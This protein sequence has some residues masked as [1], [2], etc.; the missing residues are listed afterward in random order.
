MSHPFPEDPVARFS[1]DQFALL[2]TLFKWNSKLNFSEVDTGDKTLLEWLEHVKFLASEPLST[3]STSGGLSK[4]IVDLFPSDER[5]GDIEMD[6]QDD[7]GEG[8][9]ELAEGLATSVPIVG[10]EASLAG[11]PSS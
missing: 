6:A 1:Y 11:G 8:E 10:S 9:D 7:D 5:S 3:A 2:A 4:T